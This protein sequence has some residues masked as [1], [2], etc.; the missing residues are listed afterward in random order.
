MSRAYWRDPAPLSAVSEV[1]AWR[2]EGDSFW[3]R[4]ADCI[5]YPESGGQRAD[6]GLV[7]GL[8]VRDV[9]LRGGDIW[10]RLDA[11]PPDGPLLQQVDA[12]LRL[13]H[14]EQHS[15]QH[16]LSA[17]FIEQMGAATVGFH[18][19]ESVSSIE[20]D[21]PRLDEADLRRAE[22]RAWELIRQCLPIRALFPEADA[23]AA[24]PL[25][26]EPKV[27]EN[28]RVVTI[29]DYDHSA[30]GGT[31]LESSGELGA[32]FLGRRERIRGHWRV[33]FLAGGRALGA[34]A[35]GLAALRDLAENLSCGSEELPGRLASLQREAARLPKLEK[36]LAALEAQAEALRLMETGVWECL[37]GGDLL[38]VEDFGERPPGVLSDLG[39]A[40]C[41]GS[42]RLVLLACR[43]DGHGHLL[44]QRSRGEGPHLGDLMKRLLSGGQGQGGGGADRARC[45]LTETALSSVLKV[46]AISLAE[47]D[48]G[49]QGP[50]KRGK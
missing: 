6:L 2:Q 12:A 32:V 20:L 28:L 47:A 31:H 39:A 16:L 48:S 34:A 17:V 50:Q 33:E 15:G 46:A 9:Q 22:I 30:C 3:L 40:L 23:L 45:R 27:T 11:A 43:W 4:L 37:P 14:S 49:G 42:G 10:L 13:D 24:I 44:F 29:G 35:T 25:R 7:G 8:P 38:L 36:R 1:L 26:R 41:A 19:G 5:F 21:T 18:M